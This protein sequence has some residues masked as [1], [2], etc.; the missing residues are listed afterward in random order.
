MCS[1]KAFFQICPRQWLCK[2]AEECNLKVDSNDAVYEARK[3]GANGVVSANIL[4]KSVSDPE[5]FH[6]LLY[7]VDPNPVSTFDT[8]LI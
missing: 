6:R 7:C 2:Y 3:G 8:I 4:A 5:E 1:S